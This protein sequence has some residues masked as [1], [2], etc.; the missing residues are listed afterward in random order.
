M[1]FAHVLDELQIPLLWNPRDYN[2]HNKMNRDKA[3]MGGASLQMVTPRQI[4]L[5]LECNKWNY[6]AYLEIYFIST[7]N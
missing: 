6:H 3:Q 5:F 7:K 2:N 4:K 1:N